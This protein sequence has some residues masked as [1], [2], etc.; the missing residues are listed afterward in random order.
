MVKSMIKNVEKKYY[1]KNKNSCMFCEF[2]ET[3]HCK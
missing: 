2:K 1:L 3:I